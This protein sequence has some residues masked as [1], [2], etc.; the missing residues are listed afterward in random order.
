MMYIIQKL[1]FFSKLVKLL[2][3][4]HNDD[5]YS[6]LDWCMSGRDIDLELLLE[7]VDVGVFE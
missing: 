5:Y 7:Y 4:T 1:L 6:P 3:I 2:T